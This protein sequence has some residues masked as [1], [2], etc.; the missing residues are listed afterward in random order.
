MRKGAWNCVGVI[1][2]MVQKLAQCASQCSALDG[3]VH[4]SVE[5]GK[6]VIQPRF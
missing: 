3:T 2:S 6:Q 4:K 1:F 5:V